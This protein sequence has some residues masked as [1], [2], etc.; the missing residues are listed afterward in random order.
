MALVL[1]VGASSLA[2]PS[3]KVFPNLKIGPAQFQEVMGPK[4]TCKNL[5]KN[6]CLMMDAPKQVMGPMGGSRRGE[7]LSQGWRHARCRV[8]EVGRSFRP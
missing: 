5:E 2:N 3:L 7:D 1:E 8:E 6:Q 4:E